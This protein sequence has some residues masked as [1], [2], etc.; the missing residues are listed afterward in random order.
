MKIRLVRDDDDVDE[1]ILSA[2]SLAHCIVNQRHFIVE[3]TI[4]DKNPQRKVIHVKKI[5]SREKLLLV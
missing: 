3:Q 2:I 1:I 4:A 5:R